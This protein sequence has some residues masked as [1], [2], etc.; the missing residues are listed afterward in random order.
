MWE[1][2][3]KGKRL[4]WVILIMIGCHVEAKHTCAFMARYGG[5]DQSQ[6]AQLAINI[7]NSSQLRMFRVFPLIKHLK[8]FQSCDSLER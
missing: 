6:H 5:E 3:E 7:Y 8:L 2:F 1:N 4:L